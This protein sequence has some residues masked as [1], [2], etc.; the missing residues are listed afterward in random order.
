MLIYRGFLSIK[1]CFSY[2][3]FNSKDQKARV[4]QLT[5]IGI[6]HWK[7]HVHEIFPHLLEAYKI[8]LET[9]DL[10][11][12]GYTIH[13]YCCYSFLAGISLE[14]LELEITNH[15]NSLKQFKQEN[16]YYYTKISHQAV[17]NLLGPLVHSLQIK[18]ML[19]CI[20][21]MGLQWLIPQKKP[22]LP[23]GRHVST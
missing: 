2:E 12:A 19:Y 10:E 3:K 22:C 5:Y 13:H 9:G 18:N 23:L 20:E 7:I 21:Q 11:Y 16:N 8:C 4:F 15:T 14:E 17:L 1:Y 6:E